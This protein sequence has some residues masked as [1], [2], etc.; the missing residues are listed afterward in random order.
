M[1]ANST[2]KKST[3]TQKGR[4]RA[5]ARL[6]DL[7]DKS[8]DTSDIPERSDWHIA[9]IGKFY[10]P[11]KQQVTLRIDADI[12]AWFKARGAGYQTALNEALREHSRRHAAQVGQLAKTGEPCPESGLW[13]PLNSRSA[14]MAFSLGHQ[15]P[16]H[17]KKP[18]VWRLVQRA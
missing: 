11:I 18:V 13:Q 6:T 16:P 10:R 4:R 12:I 5:I 2:K 8:I 17:Q 1:S 15:M 3:S 9:Q 7:S 14:A